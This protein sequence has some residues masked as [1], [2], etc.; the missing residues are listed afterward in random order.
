M[1]AAGPEMPLLEHLEELRRRLL[2][3]FIALGIGF[4]GCYNFAE[5]MFKVLME[6]L[7]KVLPANSTLIYTSVAEGFITYVKVALVGGFFVA[8]P[9]IFFQV[10]RFI[11]PGLYREERILII[12]VSFFSAFFF[13]AG[14]LFG[15]FV[16]F[17]FGFEFF[18]SFGDQNIVPMPAM[19]DYFSFTVTL[20]FAFGV[21]FEL[22]VFIFFLARLGLVTAKS[23]RKFQRYA[24][25]LAFVVSAIITPPDVISQ[26]MMA[27]P[28]MILYE[29]G[30][31]V[32]YFFGK[33]KKVPV[34]DTDEDD[35]EPTP[36]PPSD[37]TP[38][39]AASE[40]DAA[41]T[42]DVTASTET[43]VTE[44]SSEHDPTDSDEVD[45]TTESTKTTEAEDDQA[46]DTD[47]SG[48][49]PEHKDSKTSS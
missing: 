4:L 7:I 30:I 38:A 23:L 13:V 20:L 18:M 45:N 42:E 47:D 29:I 34:E 6:P 26:C 3:C 33:K 14:A 9:Y 16:V 48:E 43:D 36:E 41:E 32:A 2:R 28:L 12:P 17:P 31:W 11:A 22:P 15:Y 19:K 1:S 39:D 10:W 35:E 40:D 5:Q 46:S 37:D 24:L 27:L 21:V 8:S 44:T 25:L 49:T